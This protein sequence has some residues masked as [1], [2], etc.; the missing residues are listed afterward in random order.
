MEAIRFKRGYRPRRGTATRNLSAMAAAAGGFGVWILKMKM[1]S[2]WIPAA[3]SFE[4]S[5]IA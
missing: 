4:S 3:F 5:M 1:G 2:V